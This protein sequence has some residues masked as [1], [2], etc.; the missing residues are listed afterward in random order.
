MEAVSWQH[1]PK[2]VCKW[3]REKH[4]FCLCVQHVREGFCVHVG[5][6]VHLSILLIKPDYCITH[7]HMLF[8]HVCESVKKVYSKCVWDLFHPTATSRTRLCVCAA[9]AATVPPECLGR[10]RECVCG[11]GCC[12]CTPSG[13]WGHCHSQ[14]HDCKTERKMM[15]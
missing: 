8:R 14:L 12:S 2:W 1:S 15:R 4:A 13:C 7:H 10:L 11:T 6:L 9:A 3:S 5:T